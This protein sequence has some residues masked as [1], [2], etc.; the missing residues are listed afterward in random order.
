MGGS[1]ESLTSPWLG[2]PCATAI[3]DVLELFSEYADEVSDSGTRPVPTSGEALSSGLVSAWPGPF[4][5]GLHVFRASGV[6][7]VSGTLATAVIEAAARIAG[8][9]RSNGIV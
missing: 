4:N 2:R 8:K 7:F 5:M 6:W 9:S 1:V 3:R